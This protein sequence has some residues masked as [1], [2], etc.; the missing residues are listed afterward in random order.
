[1]LKIVAFYRLKKPQQ[2][3][4][5]CFWYWFLINILEHQKPN[6]NQYQGITYNMVVVWICM[7]LFVW[8]LVKIWSNSGH[9]IWSKNLVKIWPKI[10]H[11][12]VNIWSK[13][14]Q[15][16]LNKYQIMVHQF[17]D[18]CFASLHHFGKYVFLQFS[19]S[20]WAPI[21]LPS[22]LLAHGLRGS[23]GRDFSHLP[24]GP[25]TSSYADG[26]LGYPGRGTA[27]QHQRVITGPTS[28][29]QTQGTHPRIPWHNQIGYSKKKLP[30]SAVCTKCLTWQ[31]L[32]AAAFWSTD[33]CQLSHSCEQTLLLNM[34][35]CILA[36]HSKIGM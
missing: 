4:L 10:W 33:C 23:A 22:A 35:N 16:M 34:C 3:T 5:W 36:H 13:S 2:H 1:M 26:F 31:L 18:W 14:G 12:L 19:F 25:H 32:R 11:N 17:G 20:I 24:G 8:V 15:N 7:W 30:G 28:K 27:H 9:V 6:N 29:L 21:L